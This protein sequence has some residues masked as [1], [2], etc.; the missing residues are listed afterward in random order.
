MS[1]S[2][3]NRPWNWIASHRWFAAGM[4]LYAIC[5]GYVLTTIGF[6]ED[7]SVTPLYIM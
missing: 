7:G 6:R 3:K 5:L 4:T 2:G 1:D